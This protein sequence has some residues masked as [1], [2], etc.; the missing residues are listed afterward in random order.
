MAKNINPDTGVRYGVI[1]TRNIDQDVLDTIL[2]NGTDLSYAEAEEETRR[3]VEAD[4][5]A[6]RGILLDDVDMEVQARMENYQSDEP[7]V[8]YTLTDDAGQ[9]TLE[10]Q[11]TWLGGAQLLWVFK[12]PYRTKARLCSPCVPGAGDLDNP[13]PEGVECYDVPPDWREGGDE[14][15]V[16]IEEDAAFEAII[17]NDDDDVEPYVCEVV[18]KGFDGSTDETDDRIVWVVTSMP[19]DQL[20]EWMRE[21]GVDFESVSATEVH[22]S[23]A[24]VDFDLP[25]EE[26]DFLAQVKK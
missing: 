23:D 6:G 17:E 25:E 19:C 16:Q 2:Q 7:V 21:R 5:R 14:A 12:S 3:D 8:R 4:V 15:E 18:L 13:D 1:S 11:T 22:T 10:V 9:T 26:H 24:G 20:G